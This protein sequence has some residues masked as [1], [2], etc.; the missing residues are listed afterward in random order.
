MMAMYMMHNVLSIMDQIT[1]I[2]D[3]RFVSAT[4]KTP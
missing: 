3:E 1:G 4:M 2:K